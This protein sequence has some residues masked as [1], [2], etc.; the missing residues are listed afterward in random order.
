MEL[1]SLFEVLVLFALFYVAFLT[2]NNLFCPKPSGKQLPPGLFPW[3]VVGNAPLLGS[4][5]HKT[6][7]ELAEKYG[8][9]Y[10]IKLGSVKAIVLSDL[11]TIKQ[12]LVKQRQVFGGRM[13][14]ETYKY[15]QNG[16]SNVFNDVSTQGEVWSKTKLEML[17]HLHNLS[18]ST[19]VR[20]KMNDFITDDVIYMLKKLEIT[21]ET[22]F[23][24]P[25]DIIRK[26]AANTLCTICFGKR[27]DYDDKDFC[28]LLQANE[29]FS[30]VV[31]AGAMIDT[32]P[33][34]R[35][36]PKH[37]QILEAYKKAM[38]YRHKWAL[39]LVEEIAT[40][41]TDKDLL[42]P[43][44]VVTSM[45]KSNGNG[46]ITTKYMDQIASICSEVFAAGQDTTP[47]AFNWIINYLLLYPNVM[48]RMK[49]DIN[50]AVGDRLPTLFDRPKLPYIDAFIHETFRQ[51]SILPIS[52]PHATLKQ[53]ALC[54]YHIPQGIM[55]F[56]NQY[57]V[58]R[59]PNV[60]P[61]PEKFDP[62]RFLCKDESGGMTMN[63]EAVDKYLIFS[64]GLRKCPGLDLAKGWLF[65]ATAILAQTCELM[66]D[67]AHP[68]S[69]DAIPGLTL[70]PRCLRLKLRINT[71]EVQKH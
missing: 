36:F 57:S 56:V 54:G 63:S 71:L 5:P 70:R 44:N 65:L 67:P 59:D 48:K 23:V 27:Y 19:T 40:S 24:N 21:S 64:M 60:W 12:A 26:A 43:K 49:N 29:V 45:I 58:N 4:E 1:P 11:K 17:R 8:P 2:Y 41:S 53:T 15:L 6:F 68:P 25:E 16:I 52:I 62:M 30:A 20:K 69:L 35:V 51:S 55:V 61:D 47:T 22:N 7:H 14:F 9:I 42:E 37:R 39:K 38:K 28:E 18:T 13:R 32:M 31:S 50:E 10:R 34:I 3:P 46:K 66:P 33:W